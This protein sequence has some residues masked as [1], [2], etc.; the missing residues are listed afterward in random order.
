MNKKEETLLIIKYVMYALALTL[1]LLI[2]FAKPGSPFN[3]FDS[4][5]NS[6]KAIG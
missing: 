4:D 5:E 1:V 6:L 2:V 3:I